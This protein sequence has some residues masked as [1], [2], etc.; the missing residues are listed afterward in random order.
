MLFQPHSHTN[1]PTLFPEWALSRSLAH[2]KSGLVVLDFSPTQNFHLLAL[3]IIATI[4]VN[5]FDDIDHRQNAL[6]QSDLPPPEP[7][8][9][10]MTPIITELSNLSTTAFDGAH[11]FPNG[12]KGLRRSTSGN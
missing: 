9:P 1:S 8:S 7:V 12:K 3:P 10:P 11:F 6:Q 5:Q 2:E 4:L